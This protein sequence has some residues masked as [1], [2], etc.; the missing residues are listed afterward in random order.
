M[1]KK[2]TIGTLL[3]ICFFT[4]NAQLPDIKAKSTTPCSGDVFSVVPI[5]GVGGDVVPVDG[6]GAGGGPQDSEGEP[7]EGGLAGA[8]GA[9]ETQALA[10]A[11]LEVDTLQRHHTMAV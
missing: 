11:D 3:M 1:L 2:L 8:V 9:Q 10:V 5:D 4:A 7:D 6:H